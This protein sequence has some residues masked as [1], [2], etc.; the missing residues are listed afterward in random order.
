MST[1]KKRLLKRLEKEVGII[2]SSD[3]IHG[4]GEV[5][6]V[7]LFLRFADG[8]PA[9]LWPSDYNL[10]EIVARAI[11]SRGLNVANLP[12]K[13]HGACKCKTNKAE[14]AKPER[15]SNPLL[16]KN[17]GKATPVPASAKGR[18]IVFKH[19]RAIGDALMFTSG[20]RDFKLLF[21]EIRINVESN[22]SALWENNPYLDRG[23]EKDQD[24]V[25]FY[26]VG[27]PVIQGCNG[28]AV[29]FQLGFLFEMLAV[30]DLSNRLPMS[31]GEFTAAF[32]SGR[33]S[34][35][36]DPKDHAE[37]REPFIALRKKY[38]GFS[39]KFARQW[40]DVHLTDE[41]K[42]YNT[43]KELYGADKYWVIAPGG[44]R[45]CTCKMWDWRRFQAVINHFEG[46]LK[47][48][49][50]GRGDHLVEKLRNV[51]DLTDKFNDD[52]R[53]LIP[54]CY[55][56][57]GCVSGVT[58]LMH[59]AAAM[60]PKDGQ[61]SK[62][63]VSIYGGREPVNFTGYD[64]HQILHTTGAFTCCRRGGCWHSR[65]HPEMKSADAN[66]RICGQTVESEGKT[67]QACMDSITS[68]DVIRAIE[69]YY[70]GNIYT[71]MEGEKHSSGFEY[72]E[73]AKSLE[74]MGKACKIESLEKKEINLLA[75]LSSKGGGEQSALMVAKVLRDAGWK[76]NFIPWEKVHKNY[77]GV[78][79]EG[80]SFKDGMAEK[81]KPGL[82]L[83]FYANDQIRPFVEEGQGVVEKSSLLIVGIN[84]INSGL[85]KWNWLAK[86]GKLGA[87]I[88]QNEEKREEFDRDAIGFESTK[89][90]V[91][92][93]AIDLNTFLQVCPVERKKDEPLVVLKHCIPDHRKYI[94]KDSVG[95]GEKIHLW[96]KNIHK[97]LDTK[98]Y[99]RLLKDVKNVRFEFMKAH[100]ELEECFK[101]DDR[102]VFHEWNALPVTEFLTRGHVYL[103]RTSNKWRDQYPRVVA[104]ALAAGLPV[105][106]EPRDG[107]RDRIVHGDTGLYCIDYD[108][109]R[110]AL[111]LLQRKEGYRHHMGMRAKDW[112]R[113]NLD[114]RKWVEVIEGLC[115]GSE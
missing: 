70:E 46:R 108:A 44:K 9:Y 7:M 6:D 79:I 15:G 64:G 14:E 20:V 93:G 81:M 97:E 50:I 77:A 86:S 32:A 106:S 10:S 43:V 68:R 36:Y 78:D 100:E 60:P 12:V 13:C 42:S 61:G 17:F 102:M 89:R 29:G 1:F 51:I 8:H 22:F 18:K 52:V 74:L 57:E 58:F 16:F 92:F 19:S 109:F 63:C 98:F 101:D 113:K 105:L 72:K 65:I 111:R 76:V 28:A 3:N 94:T 80:Y 5:L 47:F 112:A 95:G 91:M 110:W 59:L 11:D 82:P 67:I 104:E 87:V 103:Y 107:T 27:Y 37:A 66:K 48:V 33:V 24:G 71:Y 35:Y 85:P 23:L 39:D 2:A 115:G 38:K 96:Q 114:P 88:F 83:L 99:E 56:A 54:L 55:H 41:E 4:H 34:S 31:I 73:I 40:G 26:R 75:S 62:P 84:Y 30:T 90:V 25:E 69:K 53:G 45:D 49:V 21:P